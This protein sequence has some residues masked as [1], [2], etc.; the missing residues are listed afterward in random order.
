MDIVEYQILGGVVGQANGIECL[1]KV[2]G[3]SR[4]IDHTRLQEGPLATVFKLNRTG[5]DKIF[6]HDLAAIVLKT[7]IGSDDNVAIFVHFEKC[8]GQ[9]QHIG[10]EGDGAMVHTNRARFIVT[11]IENTSITL[12]KGIG[13][14]DLG[15]RFHH[16]QCILGKAAT[17]HHR[18]SL[19]VHRGPSRGVAVGKR[20][21]VS[22]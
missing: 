1:S 9:N 19:G 10:V 21:G 20:V 5:G 12:R 16:R 8:H 4:T 3:G 7:H 22:P 15:K 13:V 11:H 18:S 14:V 6:D 17:G 2:K